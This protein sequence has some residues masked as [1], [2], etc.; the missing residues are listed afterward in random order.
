MKIASSFFTLTLLLLLSF[1]CQKTVENSWVKIFNGKTLENVL[2]T[3]H[4]GISIPKRLA[5]LDIQGFQ[6]VSKNFRSDNK[7]PTGS[8]CRWSV[9]L[10]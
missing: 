9:I 8:E 6:G 5:G 4:R 1:A 3:G 2:R 10:P 7:E